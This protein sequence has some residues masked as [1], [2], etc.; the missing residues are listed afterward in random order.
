MR[1][2]A[3]TLAG[4]A[5]YAAARST[6]RLV[7]RA[8]VMAPW[9]WREKLW[10]WRRGF[11][12]SHAALYDRQRIEAGVYLTDYQRRFRCHALNDVPAVLRNKLLLRQLLAGVGIAHPETVA[13]VTARGILAS[14]IDQPTEIT[15]AELQAQLSAGGGRF[16]FKPQDTERGENIWLV[17]SRQGQGPVMRR[18]S[19]ARAF[20][21]WHHAPRMGVLE[22]AIEQH[23]FW[24]AL[25][26]HSVNSI[27]VL[28]MWTPGDAAPFIA[29]AVQRIGTARTLPTDNFAGGGIGAHIDLQ[30]GV[31]GQG[32]TLPAA[33]LAGNGGPARHRAAAPTLTHHPDTAAPIAGLTLPNWSKIKDAALAAAR[34][35][36]PYA[37]YVGWDIAV[38]HDGEPVIIEGN[39]NSSAVLLQVERGLLEEDNVRRFYAACGVI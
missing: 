31:L 37:R 30:T 5:T 21:A 20:N 16:V 33:P 2:L 17:E 28:T 29:R 11:E 6:F 39:H 34:C 1:A 35:V 26:P 32:C 19:Q 22:R 15:S 3:Q 36:R 24:H 25:S 8:E 23:P 27:R 14:P 10:A 13:I 12:I 9:P 18:G 4:D 38:A 7:S